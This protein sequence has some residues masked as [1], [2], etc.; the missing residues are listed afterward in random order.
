MF[1]T[2]AVK[3]QDLAVSADFSFRLK[4][5][6]F[7]LIFWK[8][9]IIKVRKFVPLYSSAQYGTF[10]EKWQQ[11]F[12]SLKNWQFYAISFD[13]ADKLKAPPYHHQGHLSI[14]FGGYHLLLSIL[15]LSQVSP[16]GLNFV[17]DFEGEGA[18]SPPIPATIDDSEVAL[19]CPGPMGP[20]QSQRNF[21]IHT[22]A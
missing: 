5:S 18:Y 10:I 9:W 15:I 12:F 1:Q 20:I 13:L 2:D 14:F 19:L 6:H 21:S 17:H 3:S 7:W 4:I 16:S 8:K 22:L 11:L